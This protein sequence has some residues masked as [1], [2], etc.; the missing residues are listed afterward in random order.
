M[1]R[2]TLMFGLLLG[3]FIAEAHVD[4]TRIEFTDRE[5]QL[6]VAI[7]LP[8]GIDQL[9]NGLSIWR[10]LFKVGVQE[11]EKG[12]LEKFLSEKQVGS[13]YRIPLPPRDTIRVEILATV[14]DE[15]DRKAFGLSIQRP[16]KKESS[17][18]FFPKRDVGFYIGLN[19]W[20]GPN[21]LVRE[22]ELRW[23]Q[24]VY[25]A[26]SFRRNMDIWRSEH[27]AF[28]FS[29]A[30]E[31]V[32]Y[33]LRFQGQTVLRENTLGEPE[34]ELET[35]PLKKAKLTVPQFSLPVMFHVGIPK[36]KWTLSV[37]PYASIRLGGY[38]KAKYAM[39]GGKEK[40]RGDF[41]MRPWQTGWM[42]EVGRKSGIKLFIRQDNQPLFR[43]AGRNEK[44]WA[45][46]VRF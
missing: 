20:H 37:G 5:N 16:E 27:V 45:V 36:T 4:S 26:L 32:W 22:S 25:V 11:A 2:I 46:G 9:P 17:K 30:P 44:V 34:F 21:T 18:R 38:T 28:G 15:E 6:R 35:T 31:F 10:V 41:D 40:L 24:S 39:G 8:G 3:C 1:R 7:H 43:T 19:N 13:T 14:E 33:N 42:A 12:G 29:Y 23:P